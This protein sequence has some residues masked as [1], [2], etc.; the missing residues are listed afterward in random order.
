MNHHHYIVFKAFQFFVQKPLMD[1]TPSI[2][3]PQDFSGGG[4][5][6]TYPPL[7]MQ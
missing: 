2:K 7:Y 1:M 5:N 4:T 3:I 6:L